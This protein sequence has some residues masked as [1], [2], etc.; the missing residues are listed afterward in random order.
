LAETKLPDPLSRRHLLDGEIDASKLEALGLALLEAG[1]EIDAIECL[2]KAEAR[3][4]LEA[5]QDAAVERG[6]VFLMKS[7]SAGLKEEPPVERWRTLA[8]AATAAGRHKDAEAALRL[9]AV[10]G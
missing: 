8:E 2:A 3:E 10:D 5:L 4:P 7:A 1:R 9:A 6:D